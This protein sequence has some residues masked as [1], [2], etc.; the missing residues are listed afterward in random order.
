MD[1]PKLGIWRLG[2]DLCGARAS[3]L[4]TGIRGR[5]LRAHLGRPGAHPP[6]VAVT[7]T[8][9][10]CSVTVDVRRLDGSA[11][12]PRG[13]GPALAASVHVAA[14]PRLVT[15]PGPLGRVLTEF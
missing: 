5:V 10:D 1:H 2:E 7:L 8:E 15:L 4:S 6:A 11:D 3:V 14:T 9:E 13:R 12:A